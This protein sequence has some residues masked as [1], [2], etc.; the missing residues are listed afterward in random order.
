MWDEHN[1]PYPL[2]ALCIEVV[3]YIERYSVM[4]CDVKEQGILHEMGL[5]ECYKIYIYCEETCPK[6]AKPYQMLFTFYESCIVKLNIR[7]NMNIEIK[8]YEMLPRYYI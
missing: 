3:S 8:E 1:R 4:V 5:S 7:R 2:G 6:G